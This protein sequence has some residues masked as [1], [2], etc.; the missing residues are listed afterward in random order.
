MNGTTIPIFLRN[1]GFQCVGIF[2]L[3][4]CAFCGNEQPLFSTPLFVPGL[5]TN[6][7]FHM[8]F[9]SDLWGLFGCKQ[10]SRGLCTPISLFHTQ[11]EV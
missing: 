6:T 9:L 3:G 1:N 2:T 8:K 7:L 4:L 11:A 10:L 5:W